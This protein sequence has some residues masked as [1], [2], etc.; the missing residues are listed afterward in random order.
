MLLHLFQGKAYDAGAQ[1][2]AAAENKR[3]MLAADSKKSGA[4]KDLHVNMA[5]AMSD[6]SISQTDAKVNE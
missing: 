5:V 3:R 1:S 4:V 2:K 6:A